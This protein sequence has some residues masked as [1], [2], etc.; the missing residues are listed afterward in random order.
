[1]CRPR[2]PAAGHKK[3]DLLVP[4]GVQDGLD[5]NGKTW[6]NTTKQVSCIYLQRRK[7]AGGALGGECVE[8]QVVWQGRRVGGGGLGGARQVAPP[9]S[10]VCA[11]VCVCVRVHAFVK[12]V[13]VCCACGC[14]CCMIEFVCMH[15]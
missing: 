9:R 1:M 10:Q 11:C 2:Q 5:N 6:V 15:R 13:F 12:S 7:R 14:V 4:S 3:E 8:W